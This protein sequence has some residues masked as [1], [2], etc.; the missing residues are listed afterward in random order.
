MVVPRLRGGCR[1]TQ[2]PTEDEVQVVATAV[3]AEGGGRTPGKRNLEGG[4]HQR[5]GRSAG[6][7]K[8]ANR[9][10]RDGV[11]SDRGQGWQAAGVPGGEG[12][13]GVL[14]DSQTKGQSD[15]QK[16]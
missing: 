10:N 15:G 7:R 3:G 9:Q 8:K 6:K 14:S 11:Q 13:G 12:Q 16:K 5:R 4:N 2:V 1:A